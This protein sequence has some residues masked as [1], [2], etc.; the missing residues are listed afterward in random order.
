M[1]RERALAEIPA[2]YAVALRLADAAADSVAIAAALG[3]DSAAVPS[4]LRMARAKLASLVGIADPPDT[5][6]PE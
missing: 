6:T 5:A 1:D 2:E 3:I 4:V